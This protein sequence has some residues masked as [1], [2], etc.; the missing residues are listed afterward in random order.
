MVNHRYRQT[1]TVSLR[2][3]GDGAE[4]KI[5]SSVS[6]KQVI[7]IEEDHGSKGRMNSVDLSSMCLGISSRRYFK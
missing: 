1:N 2:F 3:E 7:G 6:C 4:V 5:S